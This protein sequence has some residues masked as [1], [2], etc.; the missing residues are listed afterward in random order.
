MLDLLQVDLHEKINEKTTRASERE[1]RSRERE[2]GRLVKL[3]GFPFA[4]RA[5]IVE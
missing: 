3:A 1:R 4:F 5:K 2:G